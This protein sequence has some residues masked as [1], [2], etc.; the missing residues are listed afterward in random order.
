MEIG[1][2]LA[3][4]H[5]G[6]SLPI[7]LPA[8]GTIA[9]GRG[10]CAVFLKEKN[11]VVIGLHLSI[12]YKK[13]AE[14]LNLLTDFVR[15]QGKQGRKVVIMGDFNKS[16]RGLERHPAFRQLKLTI[17][18]KRSHQLFPFDFDHICCDTD[19]KLTNVKTYKGFSDHLLLA[20]EAEN[21]FF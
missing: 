12:N 7:T 17:S 18:N 3:F 20:R 1:T 9:G 21:L 2:I 14:A 16:K 5:K 6:A 10:A 8:E 4:K 13:Q 19:L 11:L 15:E